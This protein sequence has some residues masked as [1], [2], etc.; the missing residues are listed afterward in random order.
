MWACKVHQHRLQKILNTFI[1]KYMFCSFQIG[2]SF[3]LVAC[4]LQKCE[5]PCSRIPS[6]NHI[7][8][9]SDLTLHVLFLVTAFNVLITITAY[10][11]PLYQCVVIAFRIL[12]LS[13]KFIFPQLCST[14]YSHG[15]W[16][17]Y[18]VVLCSTL[19]ETWGY[20]VKKKNF[21]CSC[22]ICHAYHTLTLWLY[23]PY[24]ISNQIH[25]F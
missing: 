16:W 20:L 12:V 5:H 23:L 15:L 8:C 6:V 22:M 24:F 14:S 9:E 13:V 3:W 19:L 21:L 7:V 25:V 17:E 11:L 4:M 10:H 2:R 18:S 1:D